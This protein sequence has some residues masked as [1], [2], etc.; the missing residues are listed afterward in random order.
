MLL[1]S[2]KFYFIIILGKC[3]NPVYHW[4]DSDTVYKLMQTTHVRDKAPSPQ[5]LLM[6]STFYYY[7][8]E[9]LPN[10]NEIIYPSLTITIILIKFN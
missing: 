6:F 2:R 5:R 10:I 1:N 3:M 9:I 7:L 8:K 4:L